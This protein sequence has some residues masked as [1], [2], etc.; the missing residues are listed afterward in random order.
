VSA[1]IG[2]VAAMLLKVRLDRKNSKMPRNEA[3]K[4][5]LSA[6]AEADSLIKEASIE[7]KDPV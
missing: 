1:V 6:K 7:A 2:C 3:E 5:I 4:I